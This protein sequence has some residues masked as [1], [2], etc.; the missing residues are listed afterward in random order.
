MDQKIFIL[1]LVIF[2]LTTPLISVASNIIKYFVYLV[3]FVTAINYLNPNIALI[4]KEFIIK[5]INLD[6]NLF[7]NIISFITFY[8][9]KYFS[10]HLEDTKINLNNNLSQLYSPDQTHTEHTHP[11]H[12]ELDQT[13]LDL[14]YDDQTLYQTELDL[15]YNNQT[16][17]YN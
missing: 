2:L 12:T 11:E 5:F 16:P 3:L 15:I 6:T 7:M 8:T 4:I 9:K 17:Q 14:V 1:I 13:E 10:Q